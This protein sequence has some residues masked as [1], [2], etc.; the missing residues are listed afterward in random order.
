MAIVIASLSKLRGTDVITVPAEQARVLPVPR[1]PL[2][3][4]IAKVCCQRGGTRRV[5]HDAGLDHDAPRTAGQ[6][7]I[8]RMG[9]GPATTETGASARGNFSRAGH[10]ATGPLHRRQHLRHEG[11]CL[12]GAGGADTPWPNP[13]FLIPVHGKCPAPREISHQPA[14]TVENAILDGM[15][16]PDPMLDAFL[17]PG[18]F[19]R[20]E[21]S[22]R[23]SEKAGGHGTPT[24][25]SATASGAFFSCPDR[26]AGRG[27]K[28]PKSPT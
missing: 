15:T 11:P 24:R 8:G 2:P 5:A 10:P 1:P 17:D 3:A 9:G 13:E 4:E 19:D 16:K 14:P 22:A 18:Q 28:R 26:A 27:T 20:G 12:P 7:A 21:G 6:Q 23:R 25:R